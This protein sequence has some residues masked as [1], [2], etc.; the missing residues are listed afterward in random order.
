MSKIEMKK[1]YDSQAKSIF[2]DF[3][4]PEES[5]LDNKDIFALHRKQQSLLRTE[6]FLLCTL[7]GLI[8]FQAFQMLFFDQAEFNAIDT[9]GITINLN[10]WT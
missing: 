4:A 5:V 1:H 10:Y 3:D 9:N 7:F 2:D 8:L 6:R